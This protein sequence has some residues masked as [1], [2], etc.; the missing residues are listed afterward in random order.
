MSRIRSYH[1]QIFEFITP[2]LILDAVY[3]T[4]GEID[5]DPLSSDLAQEHIKANHY[6]TPMDDGFNSEHPWEGRV[7]CFPPSGI[8]TWDEKRG[9]FRLSQS[10]T[11]S[12]VS[13]PV[14]G[15]QK[16]LAYYCQDHIKEGILYS[17]NLEILR[18]DQRTFDFPLCVPSF[19]PRLLRYDGEN[20]ELK[21]SEAG[22]F[23][24]FPNSDNTSESI[25]RFA[26]IFD[27]FGRIVA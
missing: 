8:W 26:K 14:L 18:M 12:G 23:I 13:G 22:V 27:R 21:D 16:M 5:L 4:L 10:Y 2:P 9:K 3:A 7:Y 24:Y 17:N 25:E 15:F 19:R 6:L 1:N 20:I 11:V